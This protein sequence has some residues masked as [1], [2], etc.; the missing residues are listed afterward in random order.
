MVDEWERHKT[1]VSHMMTFKDHI[2][3]IVPKALEDDLDWGLP[4][5]GCAGGT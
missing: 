4:V 2:F 1:S 3:I 5:F